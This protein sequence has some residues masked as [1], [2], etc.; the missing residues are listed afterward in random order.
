MLSYGIAIFPSK[1]LQDQANAYR[2]R[3]D[4][5]YLHI[6]PHVTLKSIIPLTSEEVPDAMS[7]IEHIANE[8]PPFPMHVYKV[9]T[10][11][12]KENKIFFK[13][14]PDKTL[15]GLYQRL[16]EGWLGDKGGSPRKFIPHLTVGQDLSNDEHFDVVGR[17]Q[18]K[19]IDHCEYIDRIHLLYQLDNDSW[20]V[21]ETFRLL[22][23]ERNQS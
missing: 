12:P 5:H 17:L 9:D 18:L 4:S 2:K 3:Y 11:H 10:F 6:V 19:N 8:T 13:I 14:A 20:A 21:Y 7:E 16:N 15:A 22:G 1:S 23:K